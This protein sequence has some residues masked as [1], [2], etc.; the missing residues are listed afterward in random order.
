MVSLGSYSVRMKLGDKKWLTKSTSDVH[1][2][3]T[4]RFSADNTEVPFGND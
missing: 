2:D 4:S 1:H 3:I